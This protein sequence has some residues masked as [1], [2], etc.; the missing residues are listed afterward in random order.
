M[1]AAAGSD[2]LSV[3]GGFAAVNHTDGADDAG[4]DS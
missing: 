2:R 3:G 4:G 1:T